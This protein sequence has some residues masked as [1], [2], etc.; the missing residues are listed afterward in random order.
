MKYIKILHTALGIIPFAWLCS[1]LLILFIGVFHFGYVPKYGNPVDP[2]ALGLDWIYSFEVWLALF[3][4]ISFFVWPVLTVIL[5]IFF[6]NKIV[7]NKL[8]IILFI[9]GI[10]GFFIFRY[11]FSETFLWVVD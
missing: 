3:G 11:G 9:I 1:L 7:M 6:K 4:F 5:Y 2:Y 10:A 8:S